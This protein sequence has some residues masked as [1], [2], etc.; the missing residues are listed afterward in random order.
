M[1]MATLESEAKALIRDIFDSIAPHY[2]LA[3]DVISL[4]LHRLWRRKAVSFL[5]LNGGLLL[6]LGAGTGSMTALMLRTDGSGCSVLCD[7]SLEMLR[8]ARAR[9]GGKKAFFVCGDG[10]RMPF[11]SD[12]FAGAILGFCLRNMPEVMSGL[13]ECHRVVIPKGR[14]V[15]LETSQPR[16]FLR[17]LSR[18]YFQVFVPLLGTWVTGI[19]RSYEHLRDSA[20]AFPDQEALETIMITAGWKGVRYRSLVGGVAAIHVGEK[21]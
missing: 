13:K 6:D 18:I 17:S 16:G 5:D 11:H 20:L 3:N 8:E 12:M 19:R 15:I 10:E 4:G 2:D 21:T 9:L 7:L 1:S 14:V